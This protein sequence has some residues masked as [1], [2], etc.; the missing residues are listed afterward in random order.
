MSI[1][2]TFL[3]IFFYVS[4][5]LVVV[6]LWKIFEKA[7]QKGWYAIIPF[8]NIYIWIKILEKP[9]WW[10][11]LFLVPFL[12]FFIF[13]LLVWE[14][15]RAYGKKS[16]KYLI[17]GTFFGYIYLPYLAFSE[18]E[19][20]TKLSELPKVKKTKV[21][22]WVDAILFAVVAAY[23][24]RGFLIEFYVIPTS[25]M[26]GSLMVGDYLAVSKISYGPKLPQTPIAFPF[27]HHTLP[28][29][30]SIKSYVEWLKFPFYRFFGLQEIKRGD[31]VVFNYPD[32]DTV[33]LEHQNMSYYSIVREQEYNN[34]L[35]FGDRYMPGSGFRDVHR[36]FT[37]VARPVDKRENYIKRCV[38]LP[39][40]KLQIKDGQLYINDQKSENPIN[41][42]FQYFVYT[43]GIEIS[44][45]IRQKYDINEDDVVKA[46]FFNDMSPE[47]MTNINS[48]YA[49]FDSAKTNPYNSI[50]TLTE[51]K[52]EEFRKLPNVTKIERLL[53]PDTIWDR[54][55]FPQHPNYRWNR[56]NYGPIIMP[57]EGETIK[58]DTSNLPLYS[59]IIE[60]YE[61][62]TL[63]VEGA[64]ILIN[65]K[66]ANSYTFKMNYYWLM[67]DNRHNSADSRF[68]GFVPE[69][70]VVGKAI[71]VW[72]SLDKFKK[73]NDG[74]I[75]WSRMF[76]GIK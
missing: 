7:E 48:I 21:Q 62:N 73:W 67:G 56:D 39:G 72:L 26:E 1:S 49:Y 55:A 71:F 10:F 20:F 76:R 47:T 9:F 53:V 43:N 14:T 32:G 36:E 50:F 5:L 24:I 22:E 25:S 64:K 60:A 52:V 30:K 23:I 12:G 4:I 2:L 27:A 13:L 42:Q 29:T 65:G 33:A 19:K 17:L 44:K 40:D 70:H 8:Y 61:N 28:L 6:A 37:I 51:K 45:K 58:L 34:Q 66:G 69:D 46:N 18:K 68:W 63:K 59:R 74:K 54:R 38:A 41:L 15:I 75:R 3:T 11:L 31:A 35:Q 16:Y 57:K